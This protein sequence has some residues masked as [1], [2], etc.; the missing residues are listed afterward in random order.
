MNVEPTTDLTALAGR[1][2]RIGSG[3]HAHILAIR[4]GADAVRCTD[5]LEGGVW[6]DCFYEPHGGDRGGSSSFW[7]PY[8]TVLEV[9]P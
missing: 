7:W 9:Q 5:A 1:R 4:H 3:Q 2:V 6:G 8:G